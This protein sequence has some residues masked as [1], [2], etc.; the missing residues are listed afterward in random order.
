MS[1][2]TNSL[3]QRQTLTNYQATLRSIHEAQKQVVSGSRIHRPSDDPVAAGTVVRTDSQLRAIEQYRRNIGTARTRLSA[4][5][6]VLGS[7]TDL[8][9]RAREL[10]IANATGTANADTRAAAKAEVEQLLAEAI[11]LGNTRVNGSYLFGGAFDDRR[12]FDADGAF[13]PDFPPRDAGG[14]Q[15][16]I[17]SGH[18]IATQHDGGTVFIDSEVFASLRE[19]ADALG[20]NDQD[21]VSA[22]IASVDRAFGA[23]QDLIAEV[24]ARQNALDMAEANLEAWDVQL[25]T[26][27]SDLSDVELE[28]ALTRLIHQQTAYQAA[29]A[30]NARILQTSLTDY[31]R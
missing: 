31:L 8:L 19:L 27:R 21:A 9:T 22:S 28:E 2:I 16:E 30:A 6:S 14:R 29:L 25:K 5:E 18:L 3:L 26:F 20:A 23:V 12:P 4:E 24:G 1:R 11:Q 13:D 7:L 17:A 15:V 10:A